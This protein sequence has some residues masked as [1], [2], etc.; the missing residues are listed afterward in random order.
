MTANRGD[1]TFGRY[2]GHIPV[3]HDNKKELT[4]RVNHWG[5]F[6]EINRRVASRAMQLAGSA[7]LDFVTDEHL[8]EFWED[9]IWDM[10][11]QTFY[12]IAN[13]DE[14]LAER[15]S[16]I[17]RLYNSEDIAAENATYLRQRV[18]E[19]VIESRVRTH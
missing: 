16:A 17:I 7:G 6:H 11:F 3:Q 15:L 12:D 4:V 9:E 8:C 10:V 13:S 14:A 1:A 19:K 2:Y 18:E 5:H